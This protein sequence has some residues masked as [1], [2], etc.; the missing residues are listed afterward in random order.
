MF[1]P[2]LNQ[3]KCCPWIRWQSSSASI[4]SFVKWRSSLNCSFWIL[5]TLIIANFYEPGSRRK[6]YLILR[7]SNESAPMEWFR[8]VSPATTYKK[9]LSQPQA[10]SRR[11]C[12][13]SPTLNHKEMQISQEQ[14]QIALRTGNPFSLRHSEQ[15]FTEHTWEQCL[16]PMVAGA[17]ASESGGPE[18]KS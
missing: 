11:L 18:L 6:D 4:F 5:L 1:Y 3:T 10:N 8:G 17:Q 16:N 13:K 12:E 9:L 15:R 2:S 7:S 14:M